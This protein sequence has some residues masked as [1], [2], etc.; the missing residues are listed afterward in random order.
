MP[1][2]ADRIVPGRH[3]EEAEGALRVRRGRQ[4]MSGPVIAQLD[5]CPAHRVSPAVADDALPGS[6]DGLR[7]SGD[8]KCTKRHE[9]IDEEANV[10]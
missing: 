5:L 6:G 4:G 3:F 2:D 7:G 1:A 8:G 9:E 10:F